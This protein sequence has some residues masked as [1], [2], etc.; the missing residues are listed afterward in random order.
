MDLID[1]AAEHAEEELANGA[2]ARWVNAARKAAAMR[3]GAVLFA[4]GRPLRWFGASRNVFEIE[5][6][7]RIYLS[8]AMC[9]CCLAR[10]ADAE[11]RRIEHYILKR[12]FNVIDD[13]GTGQL[14]ADELEMWFKEARTHPP[15]THAEIKR[16]KATIDID[17]SGAVSFSELWRWWQAHDPPLRLHALESDDP[18]E[19]NVNDSIESI[20]THATMVGKLKRNAMS[21]REGVV[22]RG[23]RSPYAAAPHRVHGKS[24]T[25]K[26]TKKGRGGGKHRHAKRAAQGSGDATFMWR[27]TVQP[28]RHT[29][30]TDGDG[31]LDRGELMSQSPTKNK[32]TSSITVRVKGDD[33]SE[34]DGPI[35]RHAGGAA[36]QDNEE[37]EFDDDDEDTNLRTSISQAVRH[38]IKML[39]T[40]MAGD[41]DH[42]WRVR[43]CF[44]GSVTLTGDRTESRRCNE[45]CIRREYPGRLT[46]VLAPCCCDA[47]ACLLWQSLVDPLRT[48]GK[49]VSV[50]MGVYFSNFAF[51]VVFLAVLLAVA[52][53]QASC[54]IVFANNVIGEIPSNALEAS[55][56]YCNTTRSFLD[57]TAQKASCCDGPYNASVGGGCGHVW[58]SGVLHRSYTPGGMSSQEK[59]DGWETRTSHFAPTYMGFLSY[60]L[61]FSMSNERRFF[62]YPDRVVAA[63]IVHFLALLLLLALLFAGARRLLRRSIYGSESLDSSMTTASDFT[64]EVRRLPPNARAEDVARLFTRRGWLV[65]KVVVHRPSTSRDLTKALEGAVTTLI[66]LEVVTRE[67]TAKNSDARSRAIH[68]KRSIRMASPLA[69]ERSARIAAATTTSPE[70]GGALLS[71]S[72]PSTPRNRSIRREQSLATLTLSDSGGTDSVEMSAANAELLT[73]GDEACN[74]VERAALVAGEARRDYYG[75]FATSHTSASGYSHSELNLDAS[76]ARGG[77]G[78][79]ATVP[80]VDRFF[81]ARPLPSDSGGKSSVAR[82]CGNTSGGCAFCTVRSRFATAYVSFRYEHERHECERSFGAWQWWIPLLCCSKQ[83]CERDDRGRLT[84]PFCFGMGLGCIALK[85]RHWKEGRKCGLHFADRKWLDFD[86]E[87]RERLG[88]SRAWFTGWWLWWCCSGCIGRRHRVN[89]EEEA[90]GAVGHSHERD[91]AWDSEAV[92]AKLALHSRRWTATHSFGLCLRHLCGCTVSVRRAPEPSDIRWSNLHTAVITRVAAY[93]VMIIVLFAFCVVVSLISSI[94]VFW[95]LEVLLCATSPSLLIEGMHCSMYI[96]LADWVLY[97]SIYTALFVTLLAT[98]V[99]IPIL[100]TH[101]SKVHTDGQSDAFLL[102]TTYGVESMQT[103]FFCLVSFLL[104]EYNA[105]ML[106]GH[107]SSEDYVKSALDLGSGGPIMRQSAPEVENGN[108]MAA[109]VVMNAVTTFY[110]TK[111]YNTAVMLCLFDSPF[112]GWVWLARAFVIMRKIIA[113]ALAVA[114][115]VQCR[116]RCDVTCAT[117]CGNG[118]RAKSSSAGE[119]GKSRSSAKQIAKAK[120]GCCKR[121]S[122]TLSAAAAKELADADAEAHAAAAAEH[123]SAAALVAGSSV[124]G[125]RVAE[126]AEVKQVA[127]GMGTDTGTGTGKKRESGNRTGGGGA[128]LVDGGEVR[129]LLGAEVW[130]RK[131]RQP[132]ADAAHAAF[133]IAVEQEKMGVS[134]ETSS[135]AVCTTSI[136]SSAPTAFSP[137]SAL[138]KERSGGGGGST[139]S[140]AS[141]RFAEPSDTATFA[142]GSATTATAATAPEGS[143]LSVAAVGIGKLAATK[144]KADADAKKARLARWERL[145]AFDETALLTL[146]QAEQAYIDFVQH[147]VEANLGALTSQQLKQAYQDRFDCTF[148][149]RSTLDHDDSGSHVRHSNALAALTNGKFGHGEHRRAFADGVMKHSRKKTRKKRRTRGR[150]SP[151]L[152]LYPKTAN[153]EAAEKKEKQEI[154]AEEEAARHEQRECAMILTR[155]RTEFIADVMLPTWRSAAPAWR[156]SGVVDALASLGFEANSL[157]MMEAAGSKKGAKGGSSLAIEI[158]PQHVQ[159]RARERKRERGERRRRLQSA[160]ISLHFMYYPPPP[161]PYCTHRMSCRLDALSCTIICTHRMLFQPMCFA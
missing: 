36:A 49:N 90:G 10:F 25:T 148:D 88:W 116:E 22:A 27:T 14:E 97:G 35:F 101:L 21:A 128:K 9:G 157:D 52:S 15:L 109:F 87:A 65:D 18:I 40:W 110:V 56:R 23:E 138:R 103:V 105:P 57:F 28:R 20:K 104:S 100:A 16:A 32:Q 67:T 7:R 26:K 149:E 143:Y 68:K 113:D 59:L 144:L 132:E 77:D 145:H 123:E 2:S 151:S 146:E 133:D 99:L 136:S 91:F 152:S 74:A 119:K 31:V 118:A 139:R 117:M 39:P 17:G 64:V 42:S 94:Y 3:F 55:R 73:A 106:L 92:T 125:G 134:V 121:A 93:I 159:V 81:D 8:F 126:D 47:N 41:A 95:K 70:G 108:K 142:P 82:A 53:V 19:V 102:V 141:T 6:R 45:A 79:E 131:R 54:N 84:L 124:G 33:E 1:V 4:D 61:L 111:M 161:P 86:L 71:G 130:E 154:A 137:V 83:G 60:E 37:E 120:G 12:A 107:S 11:D 78:E 147:S 98:K 58:R 153:E 114:T 43:A 155:F 34:E 51:V 122:S 96:A 129:T 150:G 38:Q 115:C 46:D 158:M 72:P 29:L 62:A 69:S 160:H 75:P 85:G 66:T 156:K 44:G 80:K 30:D 135:L 13:D 24:K 76:T 89:F 5:L 50:E 140:S 48:V 112:M 127:E 63:Y